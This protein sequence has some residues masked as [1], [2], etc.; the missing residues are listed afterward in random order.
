MIKEY[1]VTWRF[2]DSY[3]KWLT[4]SGSFLFSHKRDMYRFVKMM[5]KKGDIII[6]V[7]NK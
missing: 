5:E 1:I 4:V 6:S 7:K 2:L 3:D